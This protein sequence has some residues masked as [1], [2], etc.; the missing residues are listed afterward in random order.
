[1]TNIIKIYL[2]ANVVIG[3]KNRKLRVYLT[4]NTYAFF[5]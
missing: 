3:Q 2:P 1:M 4:I 5:K